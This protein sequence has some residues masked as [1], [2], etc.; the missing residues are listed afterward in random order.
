MLVRFW[1]RDLFINKLHSSTGADIA[2]IHYPKQITTVIAGK[3]VA[4]ALGTIARYIRVVISIK[5]D[6][7]FT[8][9]Y[10]SVFSSL[11]IR[12]WAGIARTGSEKGLALRPIPHRFRPVLITQFLLFVSFMLL[13]IF[14][15]L[16]FGYIIN[17][18]VNAPNGS[19]S[20]LAF[21]VLC[22]RT[23]PSF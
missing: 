17:D 3:I 10:Y 14:A 20:R 16:Y 18:V 1:T 5:A 21:K 13:F 11:M 7:W 15:S 4:H 22:M 8:S 6:I 12:I 2:D 23:L 19:L 9:H